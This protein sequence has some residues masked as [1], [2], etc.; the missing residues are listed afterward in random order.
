VFVFEVAIGRALRG[1]AAN[2][3]PLLV[4]STRT[5]RRLSHDLSNVGVE[6]F[7]ARF[8]RGLFGSS[9]RAEPSF[10]PSTARR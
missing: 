5:D 6:P 3:A 10:T 1:V 2:F 4:A 7:S 9:Q 8:Q